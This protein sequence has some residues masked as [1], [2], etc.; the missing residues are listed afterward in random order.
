MGLSSLTAPE[1]EGSQGTYHYANE[2]LLLQ[3]AEPAVVGPVLG[4]N[5]ILVASGCC[6]WPKE[7]AKGRTRGVTGRG[8]KK[9][10]AGRAAGSAGAGE[11]GQ[12]WGWTVQREHRRSFWPL[13]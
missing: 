13:L 2:N 12:G 6:M 7:E 4:L 3:P 1:T 11:G 5:G 9:G 8:G 10:S